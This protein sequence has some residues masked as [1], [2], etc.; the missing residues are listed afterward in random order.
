MTA[1]ERLYA[2]MQGKPADRVPVMP[3]FMAC[4][5]HFVQRSYRD[6]YLDAQVLA[7]A[8]IAIHES[9]GTDQ[10]T[11]LTDPWRESHDF[12]MKLEY[13][14]EGV[15][16]PVDGPLLKRPG[17]LKTLRLPDLSQAQRMQDRINAVDIL[18]RQRGERYSVLGWVEGPMAMYSDLRGLEDALIE[19]MEEPQAFHDGAKV[20]VENA[21]QFARAQVKAGADM[22]GMGDAACSVMGPQLYRQHI[23]TYE[24]QIFGAIHD[25]GAT[26]RMHICGNTAPLIKDIVSTGADII[27]IDWMVPL[28][29]ARKDAGERVM[30]LGNFDPSA[31]LLQGTPQTVA[32]A[33][34]RCLAEGGRRFGLM[35]GCE[36]PPG[37]PSANLR[38]FCPGEG[39]LIRDALARSL[40]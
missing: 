1:K 34:R 10:L 13:P 38:A 4:A 31:V 14:P 19:L 35:P 30:L 23:V 8:Q 25:M 17:D 7:A 37:T 16:I 18:A 22:I 21:I 11:T 12:G 20:L 40:S 28:A 29:Q 2:T 3:I 33:A 32:A 5:A 6:F 24:K 27:D 15:G 39:S 9:C 36:V 26:C